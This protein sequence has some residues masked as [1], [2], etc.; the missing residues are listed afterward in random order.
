M[1]I[2]LFHTEHEHEHLSPT[3]RRVLVVDDEPAI[4]FAYKKLIQAEGMH[5]DA[6]ET[7][8]SALPLVHAHS[9]CAVITDIR[10]SGTENSDGIRLLREVRTLQPNAKTIVITGFGSSDVERTLAE[11]GASHYFEKPVTPL[12]IL[13]LLKAVFM[14]DEEQATSMDLS[15]CLP[16]L[17]P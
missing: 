14:P 1:K 5:V 17:S 9:Y 7:L 8:E 2:G 13:D 3:S 16:E 6:C 4:L 12:L 11:L 15:A 10:L